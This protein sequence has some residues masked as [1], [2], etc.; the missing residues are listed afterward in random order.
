M[1]AMVAGSWW[2]RV[3]WWGN[4]T[5]SEVMGWVKCRQKEN[6]QV[7]CMPAQVFLLDFLQ[8]VHIPH[9]LTGLLADQGA[10]VCVVAHRVFV[11][12]CMLACCMLA[13]C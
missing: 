10:A 1:A 4:I 3:G 5:D 2:F 12:C 8:H 11:A 13:C 7:D 6:G 9:S